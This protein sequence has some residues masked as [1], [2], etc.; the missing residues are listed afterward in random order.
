MWDR[1]KA[2][3]DRIVFDIDVEVRGQI[4]LRIAF[5]NTC[6]LVDW[7]IKVADAYPLVKFSG[8][9]GFHVEVPIPP[10]PVTSQILRAVGN[11]ICTVNNIQVADTKVWE[12]ARVFRLPLTINTKT[13]Y[14]CIPLDP[15]KLKEY[16]PQDILHK[17]KHCKYDVPC[18]V[19]CERIATLVEYFAITPQKVTYEIPHL[20]LPVHEDCFPPCIRKILSDIK[21]GKN[22]PHSARF[23]LASFLLN[24]GVPRD[25]IVNV[26]SNLPDFDYEKT[27]Y[28]VEHIFGLRG[29]GVRYSCPSCSTLKVWNLCP[30]DCPLPHPVLNYKL[31]VKK[32]KKVK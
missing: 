5:K 10:K 28:Q 19:E 9:K 23:T 8:S 20:N 21:N 18:Y 16:T 24:I 6:K 25:K 2:I 26:F 17:A 30:S 7:L 12:V 29:R 31:C 4:G 27:L 3:A 13:G 1:N 14:Y 15:L 22:V 11:Y 32:N